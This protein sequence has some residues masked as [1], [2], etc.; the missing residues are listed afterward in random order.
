MHT[1]GPAVDLLGRLRACAPDLVAVE[2]TRRDST[3]HGENEGAIL[4]VED[5]TLTLGKWHQ[6][7]KRLTDEKF[8]ITK[9]DWTRF[10]KDIST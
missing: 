5:T 1:F 2:W 10:D 4:D 3:L 7:Q 8:C 9:D 6:A